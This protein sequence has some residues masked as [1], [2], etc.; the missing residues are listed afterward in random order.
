MLIVSLVPLFI[1]LVLSS[2]LAH[3]EVLSV[4]GSLMLDVP[5]LVRAA[6]AD[7]K[8]A[9]VRAVPPRQL[10]VTGLTAGRTRVTAW[11]GAGKAHDFDLEVL[12]SK[13]FRASFGDGPVPV[14][15][16]DLEFLEVDLASG[17]RVGLKWPDVVEGALSGSARGDAATVAG[18]Y[19]ATVTSGKAVLEALVTEG[20]ARILSRPRLFVRLGEAVEFHSGGEFPVPTASERDGHLYPKIE[21]KTFGLSTKVKPES[22]DG[23]HLS[24]DV[25]V[26]ISETDAS[27]SVNGVPSLNRRRLTTKMESLDSETV[28]L[29]G[30]IRRVVTKTKEGVPLLSSIPLLGLLFSKTVDSE[31]DSEI[32]IALTLSFRTRDDH[33]REVI[34]ARER[35]EPLP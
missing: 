2:A 31:T 1:L 29:S 22:G 30:L 17:S 27:L 10:F 28:L 23:I 11:D 9:R 32:V 25:Q 4:G 20:K 18:S 15:K 7:G 26:E 3:A 8:I 14:V 21:W 6:V 35:L 24:S 34:G 19:A 33:Q 13:L 5:G 12:P 16:V